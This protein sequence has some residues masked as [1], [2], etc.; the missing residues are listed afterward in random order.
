MRI[1][2]VGIGG[3]IPACAG[4][5]TVEALVGRSKWAY[6][7][8]CG[9]TGDGLVLLP[10]ARGLSPRVRGNRRVLGP[11]R[12]AARPIPA[13]AGEPSPLRWGC[14]RVWAYPR[15]CG[16]TLPCPATYLACDGLSPRVRGNPGNRT[17]R[18]AAGRPIPACA[19][20]PL[21]CGGAYRRHSAYPRVCGGTVQ[22][23][24]VLHVGEGLSPRVRGNRPPGAASRTRSGPIPACA[25]EPNCNIASNHLHEAYPRVCGGTV[26]WQSR[27]GNETGLSPRVRG[28]PPSN[29]HQMRPGGPIPACAGEPL[30]TSSEKM[31]ATAY[32]R[33]CGGT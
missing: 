31:P 19:G 23:A 2:T 15:V 18:T 16:G 28:N 5:P 13:C 10:L 22:G 32:P 6:P 1:D 9:G 14:L 12:P 30:A 27:N 26:R 24:G 11:L 29:S 4:E 7:R 33:V 8:V 3:P 25:G 17:A 21:V 20:E